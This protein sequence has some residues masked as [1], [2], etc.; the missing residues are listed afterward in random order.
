MIRADLDWKN[1]GFGLLP[2]DVNV[3]YR[4]KDGA[5]GAPEYRES[6]DLNLPLA[7]TA[8]HY[9]QAIFEG[10]KAFETVDGRVVIFRPFENAA[11]MERGAKKL[12]MEPP[13]A[14]L[15][16]EACAEIVRRNRRFVPPADSGAALYLRPF[17]IGSSA[18]IGVRPATEYIFSV[19]ST[20]VGPYFKGA[21]Q[22]IRLRVDEEVHRAAPLGVGDVKAA[23]NYAA[24][25]RAVAA[26]QRDGFDNVLY[27]DA[28]ESRYIDETGATNFYGVRQGPNGP[29]YITPMSRS[30]LES[31]TNASLVVL[32]KDL[33][34]TVER[35][36][37]DVSEVF[38]FSEAGA[39][40]T[41]AVIA[42]VGSIEY[43]GKT[44]S[45][46]EA[47]GPVT[48]ALYQELTGIQRGTVADRH[49]WLYAVS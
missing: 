46:G 43:R 35:R 29:V 25:M 9:G 6:F 24:G 48:R 39:V 44:A 42:P 47:A 8:L 23:G 45:Y 36:P 22:T 3:L 41:G 15:F 17:L 31:V 37:V 19:F 2:T 14:D 18:M 40:G 21:K 28:R 12:L 49:G 32:A 5:W 10:L 11:R 33:G 7:A 26:A 16:V 30:I 27:L 4:F 20:P 1:L 34:Y 38:E 13:P